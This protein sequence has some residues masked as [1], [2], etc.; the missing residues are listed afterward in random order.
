MIT[1]T[2]H[3]KSSPQ[4]PVK[5]MQSDG[6]EY[7]E[8]RVKGKSEFVPWVTING[9]TVVAS[10]NW[11]KVAAIRD[12]ELVE[13]DPVEDPERF[14]ATLKGSRLSADIFTF[15]Q[16]LPD[17]T[18]RYSYHHE[19]DSLAVIPIT[20]FAEWWQRLAKYDVRSAVKKAAKLGVVTGEAQFND[21]FVRG[22]VGIYDES[23]FRQGKPF[24]HYNKGFSAI[25]ELSRTYLE[26][27]IFVGAYFKN[28]LI[29]FIK[30]VR[31]GNLA[32]T[33]HVISMTKYFD[34]KPGNA[35]IAKAVEVCVEKRISHLVYGNFVYRDPKST[36]T[37]FKRRN[38]FREVLIPRYCIPLT[39]KGQIAVATGLHRGVSSVLPVT[40]WRAL[41]K[42][43]GVLTK[44]H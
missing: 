38:G 7:I 20:T 11:L 3:L 39:R 31:V 18:P 23:P 22:I 42:G 4:Q 13:G 25:K 27:S 32:L 30:M 37:E 5:R 2:E 14:I 6:A 34:K 21:A 35:L 15:A 44:L 10:G 36:F 43:R 29:G 24:W 19:W 16:R 40:L 41:V 8:I 17:A 9:R 12:E 28:E 26:R 33:L 1:V